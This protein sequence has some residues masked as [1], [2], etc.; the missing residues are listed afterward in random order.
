M[1][2]PVRLLSAAVPEWLKQA[3]LRARIRLRG[4]RVRCGPGA[5]I[6]SE[7]EFDGR[8]SLGA[9]ALV[10]GCAVGRWTYFGERALA[11][12]TD[13]GAF[14]SIAPHAVIGGGRHPTRGR[15]TTSP[16]FY[17]TIHNPWGS[18]AGSVPR[19]DEL[20]RTHVGNDV[21][22][23]YSAVVLPGVRVGDGAVVGAGAVVTRDVEPYA[24]VAGVPARKLRSRFGDDDVRWL[25]LHRWWHWPEA[26]LRSLRPQFESVAALRA[27]V[28]PS[29]RFA[30]PASR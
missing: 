13:I 30:A 10:L 28:E 18:F 15:V 25:L 16:L 19:D 23:G 17:S 1:N 27:A 22:I 3:L 4:G 2:S 26:R 24:V 5:R 29:A 7:A 8:S 11:I 9:G 21:W 6:D 12:Y 14:C 20:P